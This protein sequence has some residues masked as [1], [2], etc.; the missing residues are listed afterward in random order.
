MRLLHCLCISLLEFVIHLTGTQI[1][2]A[3]N[4][5]QPALCCSQWLEAIH[6]ESLKIQHRGVQWKQG[7]VI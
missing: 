4:C 5:Y 3:L 6:S 1:G 7:V 2:T